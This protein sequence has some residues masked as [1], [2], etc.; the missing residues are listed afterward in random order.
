[1]SV[2]LRSERGRF[3]RLSTP[4]THHR[5]HLILLLHARNAQ[6]LT[7]PRPRPTAYT[8][9]RQKYVHSSIMKL[10]LV[11]LLALG[12]SQA[13]VVRSPLRQPRS[14]QAGRARTHVCST[15]GAML[16]S[17]THPLANRKVQFSDNEDE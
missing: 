6:S 13:F 8:T 9:H 4:K 7:P 3:L 1:M 17:A 12:M 2:A 10:I 14:P 16:G 15:A 5:D 11:S